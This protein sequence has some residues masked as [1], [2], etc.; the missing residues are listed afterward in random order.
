ML[1][2]I[3]HLQQVRKKAEDDMK[4]KYAQRAGGQATIGIFVGGLAIFVFAVIVSFVR[5]L[6]W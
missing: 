6:P 5:A 4:Q 1:D 2:P 3:E